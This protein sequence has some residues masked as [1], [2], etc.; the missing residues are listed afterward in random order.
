MKSTIA[1]LSLAATL[2]ASAGCS[3]TTP[4][5]PAFSPA[6]VQTNDRIDKKK[7]PY[8]ILKAAHISVDTVECNPSGLAGVASF[9]A[10]GTAKGRVKGKFSMVGGWNYAIISGQTLWN[11]SESFEIKGKHPKD[12]TVTG[13]GTGNVA[14]CKKFGPI[15][16]GSD[17]TYH[18]G[19]KTG[20][21]STN[22]LKDGG[23]MLEQL[24]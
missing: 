3:N 7:K 21:V 19:K 13:S 23:S 11:F 17:L 24:H 12:G 1:L 16:S 2:V 14:D 9:T 18:L 10:S 22:A 5:M 6:R 15:T 20:D 8:E 4:S